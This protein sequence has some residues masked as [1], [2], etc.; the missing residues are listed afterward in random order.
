MVSDVGMPGMVQ[1]GRGNGLNAAAGIHHRHP[2][3]DVARQVQVVA[4]EEQVQA[5]L[6]ESPARVTGF[7]E[8]CGP[9]MVRDMRRPQVPRMGA[10]EE[11]SRSM[12]SRLMRCAAMP[13]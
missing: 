5:A 11:P 7:S 12:P 13:A 10:F 9:C 1:V 4:D 3:A 2:I 6:A 8:Y